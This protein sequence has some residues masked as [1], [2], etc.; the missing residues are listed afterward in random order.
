MNETRK[1]EQELMRL[2]AENEMLRSFVNT[3]KDAL[4]CMEFSEPVD[5][6]AP[7]AEII[8]QVFENE[9]H[10]RL[11][12]QAMAELYKL[13]AYKD[14]N[15]QNVRFV[16]PRN[17]ENEEFVKNLIA[18]DFNLDGAPSLDQTYEKEWIQAEND[19]RASI[20]NGMLRRM[21]GA[22]RNI[23]RQKRREQE[24]TD[25]L[26]S[27]VNVLSAI[28]DPILV[29]GEDGNLQA[30]NPALEWAFGWQLDDVLGRPVSELVDFPDGLAAL[31]AA[32]EPG[33]RSLAVAVSV[34][35]PAGRPRK[36]N[37]HVSAF[38]THNN[39]RRIVVTL[40]GFSPAIAANTG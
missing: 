30:A 2:R 38:L 6:T 40:S 23:S 39:D 20:E 11:C 3:S 32:P 12:N 24:L 25:R 26:D 10:W 27:L 35:T 17:P 36:C 8:R 14:F 31:T 9:S 34:E 7:E 16:F 13:P 5:L 29:L 18:N 19:V 21:W 15:A 22:V 4:W 28:P 33:E 37:A 1:L